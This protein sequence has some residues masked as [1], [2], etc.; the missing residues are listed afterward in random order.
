VPPTGGAAIVANISTGV[1]TFTPS[2]PI[3]VPGGV[4]P[5][6]T[7]SS[8]GILTAGAVGNQTTDTTP[9]LAETANGAGLAFY[10]WFTQNPTEAGSGKI[11]WEEAGGKLLVTFD[12]VESASTGPTVAP[13]TYQ[14]QIDMG[15]GDVTMLWTSMS[16]VTST[17]DVLVGCTLAGE[18]ITPVSQTLSAVAGQVMQPDATLSPLSLSASPPPVINGTNVNYA[19]T[20]VPETAPGSGLYLS[21]LYFTLTP[22]PAGFDL[23]GLVTTVPGCN[24]YL[25]SLDVSLGLA[26]TGTPTNNVVL[27]ISAPTFAPGDTFAAQAI[28]LFDPAFPLANGE[29]GGFLLSN[30]ILV[31]TF[32]Q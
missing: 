8:E 21:L 27:N 11:K 4:T 7:I 17:S 15:T 1:E 31:R 25:G 2:A 3:P 18:G 26:V 14:W 29:S 32:L 10:N 5:N 23:A 6:W 13:S 20:D 16:I 30:G 28:A 9:T 24:L 22:F 12:G 19:I